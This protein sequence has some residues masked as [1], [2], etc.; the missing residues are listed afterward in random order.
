MQAGLK[1]PFPHYLIKSS[2][3]PKPFSILLEHFLLHLLSERRLSDNT[4]SAYESDVSFFL[5]F[6]ANK[7][8]TDLNK[9]NLEIIHSFL[10]AC[11]RKAISNRSNARRVS[12]LNAFFS[13][14]NMQGRIDRNPFATVDLPKSGRLLPKAL[15]MEEVNKLLELPTAPSPLL[16]RNRTM[17]LLLYSTGL[18][19]TELVM[20]PLAGCN[21]E[22]G[23]LKVIG[24]GNKERL[25]PFGTAAKEG[26][27]SYIDTGRAQILK[28][29]KST[30]LFV[31]G[32]AKPMTRARFWQIIR[33]AATAAGIT[34]T[35]S[36]HMLRHSFATHLLAN[37]ADLRAVQLIL[38]HADIAT[39][40]IYTHIDQDRLKSIHRSFHPR[41]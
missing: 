31:T 4:G 13:F 33:E 2:T 18:R 36:P 29:K 39:T 14:L 7:N 41:R 38:G 34:K 5:Q 27:E 20:L 23:F 15:S 1:P 16:L 3:L 37:G 24:K 8:I 35:I 28:G 12:A 22:S 32:R 6:A 9:I 30:F 26:V 25:V 19:V 17:L 21:M 10:I 40:Q 11:R